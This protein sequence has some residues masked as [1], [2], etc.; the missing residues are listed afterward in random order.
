MSDLD[1][2]KMKILEIARERKANYAHPVS[3][4]DLIHEFGEHNKGLIQQA[5]FT[6]TLDGKIGTK[7]T[8]GG[9]N[10]NKVY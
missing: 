6:L 1:E 5:L 4:S 8:A 2:L 10:I 7:G 3:I 9:L